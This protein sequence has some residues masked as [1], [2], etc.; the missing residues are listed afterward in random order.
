V[1]RALRFGVRLHP[2]FTLCGLRP[3]SV[4][5]SRLPPQPLIRLTF[6]PPEHIIEL[7]PRSWRS[8]I[9]RGDTAARVVRRTARARSVRSRWM[10]RQPVDAREDL[11]KTRPLSTAICDGAGE[12]VKMSVISRLLLPWG[13]RIIP[14]FGVMMYVSFTIEHSPRPT[15]ATSVLTMSSP[16]LPALNLA[17][18]CLWQRRTNT[19]D[20]VSAYT[21]QARR[22]AS[23]T[24]RIATSWVK[25]G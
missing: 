22:C 13:H 9:P 17:G 1:S 7:P 15:R 12:T 3:G 21:A 14:A 20:S 25:S 23:N 24:F 11:A 10:P 19:L 8:R 5:C 4:D 6:A 18:R 16:Q 2:R